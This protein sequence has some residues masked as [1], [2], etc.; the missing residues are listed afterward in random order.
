[1]SAPVRVY[2]VPH[3]TNVTRIA[4]AAGLK[5]IPVEWVDIPWDDRTEIVRVS[6]QPLAPVLVAGDEVVADSPRILHWLE[7]R[8]PE[9]PLLPADPHA[10]A[11]IAVFCAWFNGVWKRPPNAIDA[12]RAKTLRGEPVDEAAIARWGAELEGALALFEGLLAGGDFLFGSRPTLADVTA[13]PFLRYPVLGVPADDTEPFHHILVEF[14]PLG[15][16]YPRLEAWVRR[17]DGLPQA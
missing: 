7:E 15:D 12:E 2:R 11:A 3:S 5:G 4:L 17:V 14:M 1:M 6:G 8:H 10:R 13:W 16:G 9:P